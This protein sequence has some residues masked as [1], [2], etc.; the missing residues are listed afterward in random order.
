MHGP[1]AIIISLLF[2]FARLAIELCGPMLEFVLS[3]PMLVTYS[4]YKSNSKNRS[5][6][7]LNIAAA[8]NTS[9]PSITLKLISNTLTV[10]PVS[11]LPSNIKLREFDLKSEMSSF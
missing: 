2:S 5:S 11:F 10:Y 8:V 6:T 1:A 4:Q 9:F 3:T 7:L